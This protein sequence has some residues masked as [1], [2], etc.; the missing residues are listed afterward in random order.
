LEGTPAKATVGLVLD[1]ENLDALGL[2]L[3]A[4]ASNDLLV[5]CASREAVGTM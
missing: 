2:A 3:N 1:L 5:V 4:I